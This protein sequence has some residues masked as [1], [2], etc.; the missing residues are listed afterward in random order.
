MRIAAVIL[1]AGKSE[2]MGKN[3]LLIKFHGKK[4]ID[5]IL[6]VMKDSKIDETV[7]VLGYKPWEITNSIKTRLRCV[8]IVVNEGFEE[9][10]T[11]SFKVGLKEVENADAVFLVLG[12]QP[13]LKP[14]LIN[15]M[16]DKMERNEKRFLIASPIC[17]GKKGHPVLF[18]KKLFREILN[19]RKE[20]II[21]DIIHRHKNRILTVNTDMQSMFDID[22]PD[23]ITKVASFFNLA[24]QKTSGP[25]RDKT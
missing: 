5:Y 10:M 7:I 24:D 21:R 3:K 20:E 8:K 14:K 12:D 19:L 13:L 4:L 23:D 2:R 1:A 18:S 17:E 11:S 25:E 15:A 22:T 16:I 9:G 6:D